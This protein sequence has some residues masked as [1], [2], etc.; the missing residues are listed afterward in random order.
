MKTPA[1]KP[2]T[3]ARRRNPEAVAHRQPT[4]NSNA[5]EAPFIAYH[6]G[7][8]YVFVSFDYCCKGISSNYKTAVGRS[9]KVTGPYLDRNGKPMTETGGSII[10]GETDRYSGIGHCGVYEFDGKWYIIAHAY[11]KQLNGASKLFLRP[12]R[13][14][15]GWPQISEE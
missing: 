10:A 5:I 9:K 6:D 8:Y 4:A 11:D 15:N 14:N 1:G 2:K 13:W 12:I 7:Y 3:I